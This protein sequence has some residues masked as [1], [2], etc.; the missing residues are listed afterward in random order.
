MSA[1]KYLKTVRKR[2]LVKRLPKYA[3]RSQLLE[4][5]SQFGRVVSLVIPGTNPN[6]CLR[7]FAIVGM[8]STKQ[9]RRALKTFGDLHFD[10]KKIE[11]LRFNPFSS[12][13]ISLVERLRISTHQTLPHS[14]SQNLPSPHDLGRHS[15]QQ[16]KRKPSGKKQRPHSSQVPNYRFNLPS[17]GRA[18]SP[19]CIVNN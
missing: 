6:R 2:V 11:L 13:R 9:L 18:Y 8:A 17:L 1:H 12:N 19:Y 5:F 10:G 3:S 4:Y 15:K 7:G 14:S 16:R